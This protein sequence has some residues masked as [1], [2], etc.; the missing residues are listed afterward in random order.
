MRPHRSSYPGGLSTLQ[1]T[2]LLAG[3]AG[4]VLLGVVYW[5][6]ILSA[7]HSLLGTI[8]GLSEAFA[9]VQATAIPRQGAVF[10]QSPLENAAPTPVLVAATPT[11]GAALA[12]M[13]TAVPPTPAPSS[14]LAPAPS[15]PPSPTPGQGG[16]APRLAQPSPSPGAMVS[17]S[18]AQ[19]SIQVRADA[20][21]VEVRAA[22]DGARQAVTL[23]PTANGVWT[24]RFSA[25]LS[26]GH[27]R[28]WVRARDA[29]GR[30][31]SYAWEFDSQ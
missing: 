6:A 24:A 8:N 25:P 14:T 30:E 12:S 27:H 1:R 9:P 4:L 31:G 22:L 23:E 11:V 10:K 2:L 7:A 28:V 15:P 5:L 16:R 20:D 29:A 3:M 26:A 19:V 17:G 18:V 13:P 21:L